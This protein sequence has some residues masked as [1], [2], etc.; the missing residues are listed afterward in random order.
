WS[1]LNHPNVLGFL[2]ISV[3]LGP[4]PALISPFCQSGSIMK[5]LTD[6]PKPLQECLGVISAIAHGLAYLHAEGLVHGNL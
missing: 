1:R 3:D 2:G 5:Y 6:S 4:S